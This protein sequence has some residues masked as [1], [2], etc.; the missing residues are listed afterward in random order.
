MRKH[1][2]IFLTCLLA[3]GVGPGYV[4]TSSLG[5]SLA[6]DSI[7]NMSFDDLNKVTITASKYKELTNSTPSS[8]EVV[9]ADQIQRRNYTDLLEL[10]KDLPSFDVVIANGDLYGQAYARGNQNETAD[11][12][13]I[14]I[15][16]V[17][18]QG[19]GFQNMRLARNFP[20]SSIEKVEI[21]MGPSS[22]VYGPSA[23]SGIINIITK[24]IDEGT[25]LQLQSGVGSYNS[26]F[27]DGMIRG[28]QKELEYSLAGRYFRSDDPDFSSRPGYFSNDLIAS[29]WTPLAQ[30][31]PL[32][33]QD[34]AE[35]YG[36]VA[37][38]KYKNVQFGF[39]RM[40]F[41]E[42][43]GPEYPLDKALPSTV[44][45]SSRNLGF[46]QFDH[47]FSHK[48]KS[49][50][51]L[52]Y[53][54][55]D[56]PPASIWA[57]R[58]DFDSDGDNDIHIGYWQFFNRQF[59]LNQDLV[60]QA[61]K[62]TLLSGGFSVEHN[63]F[64]KGYQLEFGNWVSDSAD[65]YDYPSIPSVDPTLKN[66][67]NRYEMINA[68]GYFQLKYSSKNKRLFFVPG[69]R[70]DYNSIY[71]N[72][73]NPRVGIVYNLGNETLL[74]VNYGTG[75]QYPSP[76]SLYGDWAGTTVSEHLE[77]E[78]I[79]SLEADLSFSLGGNAENKFKSYYNIVDNTVIQGVNLPRRTVMGLEYY[80]TAK[81]QSPYKNIKDV[82]VTFNYAY[83]DAK[84]DMIL[85]DTILPV[86][87]DP[88][89]RASDRIG[90]IAPFR[91]NLIL[92]SLF[93]DRFNVNLIN[94]YVAAR[95][96]VVSNPIE[97]VDAYLLTDVTLSYRPKKESRM[98]DF[99]FSFK[100]R[101]AL[102]VDYY[103]PGISK[104]DAGEFTSQPSMGWYSSRLPQA[105]R[106]YLLML[107]M[108]F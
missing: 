58:Y 44:W 91:F 70:Y 52:S 103:H 4:A 104:A 97:S 33:Y 60:F 27:F 107:D 72:T 1:L 25:E 105:R 12:M 21:L 18:F 41:A 19:L 95:P 34:P 69:I 85:T 73:F 93:Y 65:S 92:N 51:M 61:N 17:N 16:G 81:V 78:K 79:R 31:Y 101:N 15:N 11:R 66:N 100:I 45:V 83:V 26:A 71:E 47:A 3:L 6:F 88:I 36:I 74:K 32:D 20:M 56:T 96:T 42:A 64:Q 54:D 14:F 67:S 49:K 40:Y 37:S 76:R 108:K 53:K 106:N 35:D 22:A 59:A 38:L 80:L 84:Y 9:T 50:S 89:Y 62:Q 5:Q 13:L 46:I 87:E 10:L 39:N 98:A 29:T 7:L 57:E 30:R 24:E 86:N 99:R 77:P 2:A 43:T 75:F 90:T 48:L 94:N 23:F 68:G 8:I 63:N 82:F 55:G 102:D 28:K